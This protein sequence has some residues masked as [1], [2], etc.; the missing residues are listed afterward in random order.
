MVV[1]CVCVCV[2]VEGVTF[3]VTHTTQSGDAQFLAEYV[4]Y[5]FRCSQTLIE[6]GG[7]KHEMGANDDITP[8]INSSK[9]KTQNN[10]HYNTKFNMRINRISYNAT[11]NNWVFYE[12]LFLR[13][14]HTYILY[15]YIYISF[16]SRSRLQKSIVKRFNRRLFF[17]CCCWDLI[18]NVE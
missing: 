14:A 15:V 8:E 10:R 7:L 12:I 17:C 11:G 13:L 2:R 9:K 3:Y 5:W 1:L 18:W 6:P 4:G 16:S